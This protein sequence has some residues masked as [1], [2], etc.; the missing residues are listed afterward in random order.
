MKHLNF[1]IEK[2][3]AHVS[4]GEKEKLA[5]YYLTISNNPP[6]QSNP[7]GDLL[8]TFVGM[9]QESERNVDGEG[10]KN[11]MKKESDQDNRMFFESETELEQFVKKTMFE[12]YDILT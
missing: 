9:A 11:K 4:A 7:I 2:V 1:H 8:N 6:K 10:W 3:Y 5:G 12:F